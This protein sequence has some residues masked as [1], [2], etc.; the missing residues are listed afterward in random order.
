METIYFIF[1]IFIITVGFSNVQIVLSQEN[2][3]SSNISAINQT[4]VSITKQNDTS[5]NE[6]DFFQ[7][8]YR[9]E[10]IKGGC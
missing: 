6:S 10:N 3:F 8:I 9:C 2:N 4:D 1:V 7:D 5:L